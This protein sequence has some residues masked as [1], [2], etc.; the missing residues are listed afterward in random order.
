[1]LEKTYIE[2][3]FAWVTF[4]PDLSSHVHRNVFQIAFYWCCQSISNNILLNKG[5][6]F[7]EEFFE[8]VSPQKIL[9]Y[10]LQFNIF[11]VLKK[12]YTAFWNNGIK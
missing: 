12:T 4:I 9:T 6:K 3:L 2:S 7:F 5:L 10:L 11:T 8:N 1:M